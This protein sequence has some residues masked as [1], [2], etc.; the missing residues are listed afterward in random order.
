MEVRKMKKAIAGR[1]TVS[2]TFDEIESIPLY[3][4]QSPQLEG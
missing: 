1:A 4:H 3:R 2:A